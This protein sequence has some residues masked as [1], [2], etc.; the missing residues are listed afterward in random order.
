[1]LDDIVESTMKWTHEKPTPFIP[2][3]ARGDRT[4]QKC[5]NNY[6]FHYKEGTLG[7]A[8]NLTNADQVASISNWLVSL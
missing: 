8:A 4:R 2:L 5:A 1:M 6:G 3:Q 7:N